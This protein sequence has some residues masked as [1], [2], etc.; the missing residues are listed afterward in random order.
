MTDLFQTITIF[1]IRNITSKT[2][3]NK[4]CFVIINK[5]SLTNKFVVISSKI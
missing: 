1:I 5:N 3:V 4:Y 2:I